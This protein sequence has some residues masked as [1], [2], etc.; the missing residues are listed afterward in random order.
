MNPL[1]E[2]VSP[3]VEPLAEDTPSPAPAKKPL[4]KNRPAAPKPPEEGPEVWFACRA[5]E[6]CPGTQSRLILRQKTP[7]GGFM[8]RYR[9]LTCNRV[10]CFST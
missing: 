10:F 4:K 5:K 6:G 9:C 7:T 3:G 2:P 8:L 1:D